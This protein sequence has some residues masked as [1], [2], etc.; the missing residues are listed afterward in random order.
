MKA[1]L[2][3]NGMIDVEDLGF[4][5]LTDDLD[6]PVEEI[7]GVYCGYHSMRWVGPPPRPPTAFTNLPSV[8]RV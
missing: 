5:K 6:E 4:F 3:F 8:R 2:V 7:T 1:E